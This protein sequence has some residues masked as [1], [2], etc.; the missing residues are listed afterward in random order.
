MAPSAGCDPELRAWLPA[1]VAAGVDVVE[2]DAGVLCTG[3]T[4]VDVGAGVV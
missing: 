1:V 3:G 2:V 4:V